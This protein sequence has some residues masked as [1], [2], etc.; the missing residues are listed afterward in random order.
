MSVQ[1]AHR[2]LKVLASGLLLSVA[3]IMVVIIIPAVFRDTS[4]YAMPG[5]ATFV[6]LVGGVVHGIL[7]RSVRE[8][9]QPGESLSITDANR[10]V[11]D[12]SS[13]VAVIALILGLV[14]FDAALDFTSHGASMWAANAGMF[15]CAALDFASAGLI[16]AA[17]L[18]YRRD[19]VSEAG[20]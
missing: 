20:K 12:S 8:S 2:H 6:I 9:E 16:F 4:Q 7:G 14:L 17:R 19:R 11:A 5:V 3:G 13:R 1:P 18:L 15:L 10:P